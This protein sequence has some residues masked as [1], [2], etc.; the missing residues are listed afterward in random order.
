[1]GAWFANVSRVKVLPSLSLYTNAMQATQIR[2]G[3][4][5]MFINLA[6]GI[7]H[8]A[9]PLEGQVGKVKKHKADVEAS[10]LH[11]YCVLADAPNALILAPS[12]MTINPKNMPIL[13]VHV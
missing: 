13:R 12:T 7:G 9:H 1:M 3:D 6:V 10:R 4:T 8:V 11:V 2:T 5:V